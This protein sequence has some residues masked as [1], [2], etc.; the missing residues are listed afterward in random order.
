LLKKKSGWKRNLPAFF[1]DLIF[2]LQGRQ[3]GSSSILAPC[4]QRRQ[5]GSSSQ[6][7]CASDCCSLSSRLPALKAAWPVPL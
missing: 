3:A 4:F 5:A 2:S 6:R 7:R 1:F